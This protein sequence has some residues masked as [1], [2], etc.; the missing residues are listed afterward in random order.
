MN[1]RWWNNSIICTLAN[2]SEIFQFKKRFSTVAYR[3][4][5]WGVKPPE[6]QKALRNRAKIN[7]TVKTFKVSEFR[8]TTPQNVRKK[9]IKVLK[10]PPVRNCFTLAMTNK[11]VATINSL[12]V[13]KIKKILLY[14]MK[15]LAPNYTSFQNHWLRYYSPQIP[16]LSVLNWI[17]W[18]LL[19]KIPGY[20]T[21]SVEIFSAYTQ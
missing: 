9:D 14:E 1:R 7:P 2:K 10:L 13:P 20:A 19:N 18:T 3:G 12:K 4:G 8:M 11:L 15:F 5:C 6:I 16:V 21:E 17:C